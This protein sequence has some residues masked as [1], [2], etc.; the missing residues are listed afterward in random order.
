MKTDTL[1]LHAPCD[2]GIAERPRYFPRQLITPEDLT[3]EQ[4]YFRSR[5]RLHNR[6]LHGWGVVCGARVCLVPKSGNGGSPEP[7]MVVIKPGY[8]LGPYGDEI[9]IDCPRIFDLRKRCISGA[10]GVPCVEAPDPWCSEVIEQPEAGLLYV[11]VRYKEVS[12]RPVRVQ[13]VGCGCDDTKCEY[14]RIRDGY[15]ICV[16]N[17]CPDSHQAPPKPEDLF[18]GDEYDCPP[19]PDEPWVVLAEVNIGRDGTI[20]GIDNCKCRRLV[21]SFADFWWECDETKVEPSKSDVRV[22]S[23]EA[24]AAELEP[25][26]DHELKVHGANLNHIAAISFGNDVKVENFKANESG[27]ELGAKI[28]ISGDAAPG[29]REMVYKDAQGGG[30]RVEKAIVIAG[31]PPTPTPVPP[32]PPRKGKSKSEEEV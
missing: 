9:N 5:L 29:P 2:T 15:E 11:A 10:T 32:K 26:K 1:C 28:L 16:L 12:T 22:D 18:S 19:C 4:D 21:A 6:L 8:I 14:S 20:T 7:W 27:T 13:P 24:D 31:R 17:E 25:R 23:V 30:G 3:L